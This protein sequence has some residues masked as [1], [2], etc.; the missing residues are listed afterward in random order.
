MASGQKFLEHQEGAKCL[1][2]DGKDT[3][4]GGR[5]YQ[6]VGNILLGGGVSGSVVRLGMLGYVGS[7]EKDGGGNP[8]KI[9]KVDH[10]E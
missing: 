9:T 2:P 5:R 7:D 1:W 8:C 6:C 3:A 10:R 4:T